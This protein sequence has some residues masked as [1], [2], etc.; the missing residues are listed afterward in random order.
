[1]DGFTSTFAPMSQSTS[2]PV[3]V[4]NTVTMPGRSTPGERPSTNSAWP[5]MAPELPAETTALACPA[6]TR[7]KATRMDESRFLR[8]ACAGVSSMVTTSVAWRMCTRGVCAAPMRESSAR[9]RRS[10][11]TRIT[12]TGASRAAATAPATSG[13]GAWSPPMA[14]TAMMHGPAPAA[15]VPGPIRALLLE[16]APPSFLALA[17]ASPP[18]SAGGDAGRPGSSVSPP[19]IGAA[20]RRG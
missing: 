16:S 13:P 6:A 9:S 4:G 1:M 2:V 8:N 10:S 17:A 15:R 3:G 18:A 11:P 12:S 14:L 5:S 19:A 20:G 7:S